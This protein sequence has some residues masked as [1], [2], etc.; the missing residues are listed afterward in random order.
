MVINEC[1]EVGRM[2]RDK[3]LESAGTT[4]PFSAAFTIEDPP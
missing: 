4:V 2:N 1:G 3:G